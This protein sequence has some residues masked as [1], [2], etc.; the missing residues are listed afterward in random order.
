[1][2]RSSDR[3]PPYV[4]GPS[5]PIP[6]ENIRKHDEENQI[7]T[8]AP[9]PPPA[10]PGRK[11]HNF[12]IFFSILVGCAII[13]GGT[14]ALVHDIQRGIANSRAAV[15]SA[16][17]KHWIE[18][19]RTKVYDACYFGC[20]GCS[21]PSDSYKACAKTAQVNITGVTCDASVLWNTE[22]R[23]PLACLEAVAEI[24]KE[25]LFRSAKR[26]HLESLFFIALILMAGFVGA[27]ITDG[28]F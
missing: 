1:M 16:G 12:S 11:L 25:D 22:D 23:Y 2:S 27:A 17:R 28:I 6:L 20:N 8:G 19:A 26:K 14:Y 21:D 18:A 5:A 10:R 15:D 7:P 9:T 13:A 4:A 24:Y 3:P